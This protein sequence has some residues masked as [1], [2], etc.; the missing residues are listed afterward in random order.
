MGKHEG[1]KKQPKPRH[2]QRNPHLPALSDILKMLQAVFRVSLN[3][4]QPSS[5]GTCV[6][7]SAKAVLVCCGDFPSDGTSPVAM[8]SR[9]GTEQRGHKG[10]P[11]TSGVRAALCSPGSQ[12]PWGCHQALGLRRDL[13]SLYLAHCPPASS[14]HGQSTALCMDSQCCPPRGSE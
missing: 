3:P 11:V 7:V 1:E 2:T 4:T 13:R 12:G 14:L 8:G 10:A 9:R 6:S 5:P